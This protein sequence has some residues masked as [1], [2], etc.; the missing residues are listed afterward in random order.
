M[1]EFSGWSSVSGPV[2]ENEDVFEELEGV[3]TF[4]G[5]TGRRWSSSTKMIEGEWAIKES[6][7]GVM[8]AKSRVVG[9]VFIEI[10]LICV[11]H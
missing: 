10:L 11:S 7:G 1:V 4:V 2:Q 5:V 9:W 8:L 3:G 6:G